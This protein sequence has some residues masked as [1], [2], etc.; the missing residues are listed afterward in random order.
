MT[1]HAED[2]ETCQCDYHKACRGQLEEK[3]NL[4][5]KEAIHTVGLALL[6]A[7]NK[8]GSIHDFDYFEESKKAFLVLTKEL[9]MYIPEL[10]V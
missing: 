5:I 6:T 10:S 9:E 1:E 8:S 3:S 4:K 2:Y 7:Q